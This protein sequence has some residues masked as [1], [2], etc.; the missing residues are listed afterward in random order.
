M[1][2]SSWGLL[3]SVIPSPISYMP[4]LISQHLDHFSTGFFFF[5]SMK[6][7]SSTTSRKQEKKWTNVNWPTNIDKTK[8]R[9]RVWDRGHYEVDYS[10]WKRLLIQGLCDNLEGWDGVGSRR[11][12]Q[13][14][15]T[16]AHR[17]LTHG[18]ACRN[19]H[20]TVKQS[21]SKL[22]INRFF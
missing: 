9:I 22:K 11:E 20:K 4:C 15:G 18:D 16:Y 10:P 21:S 12:V 14:E 17:W 13:R 3:S 19:Q 2:L 7:L 5:F 6:G 8:R 1:S